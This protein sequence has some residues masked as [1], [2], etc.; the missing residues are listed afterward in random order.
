[1]D[2][3]P[4]AQAN[5]VFNDVA[6]IR[7]AQVTDG[8]SHTLF[9]TEKA[10]A[11]FRDLDAVDPTIF[12]RQ[13]WYVSGNWGDTLMTTFYPPNMPLKVAPG[14]GDAHAF[15]ASSLHP[16]GF[17]ALMGNGAVR[18][19][20]ETIDSWPFD[21]ISGNPCGASRHPDGWWRDLPRG[22]VWQA[23]ATRNGGEAVSADDF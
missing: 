5:G 8:L 6:P 21:P 9:V 13:G 10:T 22:G 16:G 17:N 2:G 4:R 3:R 7:L 18:F 1:M 11:F 23:L 19:V 20:R 12:N 15:A 14:A